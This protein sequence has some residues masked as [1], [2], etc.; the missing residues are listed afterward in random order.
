MND[1]THADHLEF[2]PN[3]LPCSVCTRCVLCVPHHDLTSYELLIEGF[4][5]LC[6]DC[7]LSYEPIQPQPLD[8][9]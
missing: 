5:H 6:R 8:S 7:F 3:A 9:P 1:L 4:L 2:G